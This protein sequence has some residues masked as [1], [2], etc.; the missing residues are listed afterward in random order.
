MN[1]EYDTIIIG[2]GP[3]GLT[4]GLYASRARLNTLL[5]EM[6]LIGG[7]MTSAVW[8]ENY[9]GFPGGI[10]GLELSQLMHKQAAEYGL[11]T[12]FAEATSIELQDGK[13]TAKTSEGN[14]I[15]KT[16]IIANGSRRAKLGVSGEDKLTG[17]GV[18]YCAIRDAASF[19]GQP[20]AIIGGGNSAIA[21]ALHAAKFAAKVTI[22]HRRKQLRA[23]PIL[24]EKAF[25]EPKIDFLWDTVVKEIEGADTVKQIKLNNP[26][27]GEESTLKVA[28]VIVSIGLK[29]STDRLS[30]L[31][32]LNPKGHI[33]TSNKME[34]EIPGIFAAGDIRHNSARQ[35]V[36]AAGDGATAATQV[37]NFLTN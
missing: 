10:S 34:T 20:V 13:K 30:N 29:P 4:A 8:I 19:Q 16:V 18:S 37:Q 27:T 1:R 17:R 7:Q 21:E 6:A 36:T 35:I 28:G 23:T 2:G 12:V 5:I 33:V 3:A 32:K 26:K 31:L 22:I 25:A 24:Q 14:F 11:K 15:T 9:P